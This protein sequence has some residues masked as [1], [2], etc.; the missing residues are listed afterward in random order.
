MFMQPFA[1]KQERSVLCCHTGDRFIP[2]RRRLN[3]DNFLY[4]KALSETSQEEDILK[5]VMDHDMKKR[6]STEI[7][8]YIVAA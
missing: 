4:T 5:Q 8:L 3:T 6:S 7:N 1:F 2:H